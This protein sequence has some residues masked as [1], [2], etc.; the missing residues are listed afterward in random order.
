MFANS[1]YKTNGK[2]YIKILT[3]QSKTDLKKY[4]IYR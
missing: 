3:N 2:S 4:Q 1:H